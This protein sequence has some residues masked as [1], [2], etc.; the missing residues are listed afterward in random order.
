MKHLKTFESYGSHELDSNR[1][2]MKRVPEYK[3]ATDRKFD[4]SEMDTDF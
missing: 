4:W 2:K 3:K 1:E